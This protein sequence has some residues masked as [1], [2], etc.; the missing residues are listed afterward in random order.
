M[1]TPDGEDQDT[2]DDSPNIPQTHSPQSRS[3][4]SPA[5]SPNSRRQVTVRVSSLPPELLPVPPVASIRVRRPRP[6][7]QD[8]SQFSASSIRPSS[9]SDRRSAEYPRANHTSTSTARSPSLSP[10]AWEATPVPP[11]TTSS[12]SVFTSAPVDYLTGSWPSEISGIPNT[13]PSNPLWSTSPTFRPVSTPTLR[14]VENHT[15]PQSRRTQFHSTDEAMSSPDSLVSVPVTGLSNPP[16]PPS[17]SQRTTR[18]TVPLPPS[19]GSSLRT[20]AFNS[21]FPSGASTTDSWGT[22]ATI[23]GE[24][25]Y[26]QTTS[27]PGETAHW[28]DP[29]PARNSTPNWFPEAS[30]NGHNLLWT[31]VDWPAWSDPTH[32]PQVAPIP[33]ATPSPPYITPPG[34]L[35]VCSYCGSPAPACVCRR[36]VRVA[37]VSTGATSGGLRTP[38]RPPTMSHPTFW[39]PDGTI[40]FEVG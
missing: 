29:Q 30:A 1:A 17:A 8:G 28:P 12:S 10:L 34:Y 35:L 31:S 26:N 23:P 22:P 38:I 33:T 19:P 40:I 24:S 20:S 2:Y 5:S 39:F 16:N 18:F 3:T 4:P 11:G 21:P 7:S 27:I 14:E 37:P 36:Y 9:L 13:S 15:Y 25:V 6:P 32:I